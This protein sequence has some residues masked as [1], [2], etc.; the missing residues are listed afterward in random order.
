MAH[1]TLS[2]APGQAPNE[3][4]TLGN[5]L[6]A[7]RYN[8]LDCPVCTGHVRWASG[9]MANWRQQ[10]TAIRTV[11]VNNDEQCA[12]ESER[13]SQRASDMSGVAPDCLVQLQD[14][15]SN[16]QIAPNPN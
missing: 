5:S 3:Q 14:K 2:G 7:L 12:A 10:S 16:G 8:S 9:A 6:G 4:A 13:R 15:T 1:W 11:R